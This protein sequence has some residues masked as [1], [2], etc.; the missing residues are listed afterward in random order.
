[1][2]PSGDGKRMRKGESVKRV[3]AFEREVLARA[4]KAA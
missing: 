4:A 2:D 3:L 1:L